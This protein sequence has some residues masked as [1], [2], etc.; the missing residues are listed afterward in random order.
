MVRKVAIGLVLLGIFLMWS[1]PAFSS[2]PLPEEFNTLIEESFARGGQMMILEVEPE[3]VHRI[4]SILIDAP[5]ERVW[6]VFTDFE[7]WS[8]FVPMMRKSEIAQREE[9]I[10]TVDFTLTV[11]FLV[12]PFR[13]SYTTVFK[14]EESK[15]FI[16]CP[17]RLEKTGFY[18]FLP[19]GEK[20]LLIVSEQSP[21]LEEMGGLIATIVRGV[22]GAELALHLSPPFVLFE[23]IKE[24]AEGKGS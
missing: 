5:I 16:L 17:E 1:G 14:L 8:E 12:I 18:K 7:S 22:P 4:G 13:H 23:A 19:A 6:K 15:I 21:C 20:T 3:R 11:R 10:V 9:N 24:R 2:E